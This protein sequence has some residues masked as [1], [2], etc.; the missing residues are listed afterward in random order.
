MNKIEIEL[1]SEISRL[2]T[3]YLEKIEQL[4]QQLKEANEVIE[5]ADNYIIQD[6]AISI[7]PL[8]WAVDEYKE[9]WGEKWRILVFIII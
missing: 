6:G 1:R 4:E 9:K 5:L 7:S 8:E 3:E 2:T